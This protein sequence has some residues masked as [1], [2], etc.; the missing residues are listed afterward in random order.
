MLAE[1]SVRPAGLRAYRHYN[2]GSREVASENLPSPCPCP[3]PCPCPN[4]AKYR[5]RAGAGARAVE[6]GSLKFVASFRFHACLA[7]P[8]CLCSEGESPANHKEGPAMP[9][10]PFVHLHCHS[11]YSLLD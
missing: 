11:H 4:S 9:E 2:N 5:A 6:S 8:A 3:C 7:L 10:R 1:P